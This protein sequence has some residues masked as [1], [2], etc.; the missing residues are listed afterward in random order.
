MIGARFPCQCWNVFDTI[1]VASWAIDRGDPTGLNF[2]AGILRMARLARLLRL[3][4]FVRYFSMFNP[5]Y[6]IVKAISSSLVILIWSLMVLLL[7][8][9]AV[10]MGMSSLLTSFIRDE[11]QDFNAR[12]HVYERWGSFTRASVS[13]FEI[14]LA[15]WGPPCWLLTNEVNEWYALFFVCYRCTI[16][17]AVVQVILSVFIQQ[18]FKVASQDERVMILDKEAQTAAMIRNLEHLFDE[19]DKSGDGNIDYLEFEVL[20][21]DPVVKTW[22]AALEVD[23][24]DIDDLFNLLDDGDG[25]ISRDEFVDGVRAMRGMAKKTDLLEIKG[26]MKKIDSNLKRRLAVRHTSNPTNEL[27]A[28]EGRC[29]TPASPGGPKPMSNLEL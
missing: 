25:P 21:S 15:N 12:T 14:T 2:N 1:I 7:F 22:F 20:K 4:R 23:V 28:R 29:R 26:R 10:A 27:Q 24:G 6:L 13:M 5:L 9:C 8:L 19:L 11:S 16:G 3:V 18:T 17:L